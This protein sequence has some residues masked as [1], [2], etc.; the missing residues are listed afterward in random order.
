MGLVLGGG[1]L[2]KG[3]RVKGY[4]MSWG[5]LVRRGRDQSSLVL[6]H[7]TAVRGTICKPEE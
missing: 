5:F 2:W 3:I 4:V 6:S 1:G 7:E